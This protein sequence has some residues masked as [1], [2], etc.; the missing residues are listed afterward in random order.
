MVITDRFIYL[1]LHKTGSTHIRRLCKRLFDVNTIGKHNSLF[2]VYGLDDA[3]WKEKN[4]IG[5]VRNPWSWYVSLWA[6]GAN[7]KGDI[8][9]RTTTLTRKRLLKLDFFSSN[10]WKKVY[11]DPNDPLLFRQW[12]HM[13]FDIK[14]Q[15]LINDTFA[16]SKLNDKVG[17]LTYRFL[18]LHTFTSFDELNAIEYDTEDMN[19]HIIVDHFIRNENLEQDFITA[20]QKSNI[21]IPEEQRQLIFEKKK[22][23]AN[24]SK[25][26][27]VACYYDQDSIELI[28]EKERF[29]IEKF[30]YAPPEI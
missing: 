3:P 20:L 15:D 14:N 2:E 9:S 10:Q 30:N 24:T 1:E 26:L 11:A 4:I 22:T 5:S 8:F 21:S 25:R 6:Y 27:P 29:I 16:A 7:G 13:I 19:R 12:L 17:I 23:K 18:H 28:K